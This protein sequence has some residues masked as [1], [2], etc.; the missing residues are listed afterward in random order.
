MKINIIKVFLQ[1]GAFI[2]EHNGKSYMR[3]IVSAGLV[4][5]YGDCLNK[6]VLYTDAARYTDWIDDQI[7]RYG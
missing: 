1:G 6:F 7:N 2:Y 5:E 3:G 4:D